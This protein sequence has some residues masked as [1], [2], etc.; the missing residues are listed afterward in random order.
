MYHKTWYKDYSEELYF[1][2]NINPL[3]PI[4]TCYLFVLPVPESKEKLR[5]VT[6]RQIGEKLQSPASNS[7]FIEMASSQDKNLE[8]D[9]LESITSDRVLIEW[10][11]EIERPI[12]C[13]TEVVQKISQEW[14]EYD[15]KLKTQ[16]SK[17]KNPLP[18]IW[19]R[20]K[21]ELDASDVF[22]ILAIVEFV[23]RVRGIVLSHIDF[24]VIKNLIRILL[25]YDK[26]EANI[27][28]KDCLSLIMPLDP[29]YPP[30]IV[31]GEKYNDWKKLNEQIARFY[32]NE[33]WVAELKKE[34]I[35][36]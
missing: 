16:L 17:G 31:G 5:L 12:R 15:N 14:K 6:H 33:F 1:E 26:Y 2:E 4:G 36:A 8:I 27:W 35:N 22:H 32:N 23:S 20:P 21:Y 3:F 25:I 34:D 28:S 13:D 24:K 29:S 18:I 30:F 19:L 7:I 10:P 11:I 9:K